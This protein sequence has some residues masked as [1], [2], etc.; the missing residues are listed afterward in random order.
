MRTARKK[1]VV[2]REIAYIRPH[3]VLPA[4]PANAPGDLAHGMR[5]AL[6]FARKICQFA[7]G[8]R[9]VFHESRLR[10]TLVRACGTG[11]ACARFRK[12]KGVV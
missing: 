9:D 11:Q 1:R 3:T 10:H 2:D 12:D 7:V 5:R 4:P 8:K 6:E